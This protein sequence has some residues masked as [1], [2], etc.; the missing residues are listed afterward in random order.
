MIYICQ[1]LALCSISFLELLYVQIIL[2][3]AINLIFLSLNLLK[4][5]RLVWIFKNF[6]LHYFIF[7]YHSL[8][9]FIELALQ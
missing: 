7:H 9:N 5:W 4:N 3:Q 8:F 2:N 1:I 6:L